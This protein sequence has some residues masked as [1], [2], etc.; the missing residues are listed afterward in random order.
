[1]K[2]ETLKEQKKRINDIV[3]RLIKEYPDSKCSLIYKS[4]FQ[5][6]VAT[7]LSAQCTDE[8]VNKV[9]YKLFKKYPNSKSFSGLTEKEIG[10]LIYS[11]GFYNNKAKNIKAMSDII[12]SK[13]DGVVPNEINL[14]VELPGVGRKT[15]NVVLG[16]V[17]NTPALVVDTH[18]TRIT[19]LLQ[20]VKTQNAVII[21]KM[22]CKIV[23]S[24][25][26]SIFAHLLIDHG[27]KI[28]IANRPKC[29]ECILSNLCPSKK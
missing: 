3:L 26:W 29:S 11:T 18:V 8:R 5:L 4:P 6:L 10:R 24:T 9:T 12:N 28:C 23:G 25:Y 16:N 17:F 13:Y 7:I 14:L 1:M 15:A 19:N 27:R 20:F 22:L 21:E 2:K